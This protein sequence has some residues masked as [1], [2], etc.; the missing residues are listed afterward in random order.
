MIGACTRGKE[1]R[2]GHPAPRAPRPANREVLRDTAHTSPKYAAGAERA[3]CAVCAG[4][5]RNLG[6]AAPIT[7]DEV[8]WA[9]PGIKLD[10]VQ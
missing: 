3:T 6:T 2:D 8:H 1:Q 10:I 9:R 7:E 5:P 4:S